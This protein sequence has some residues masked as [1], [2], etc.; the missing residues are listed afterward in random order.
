[1]RC[2]S[3][4]RLRVGKLILGI[5]V[6][7]SFYWN[8]FIKYKDL[9]FQSPRFQLV[10]FVGSFSSICLKTKIVNLTFADRKRAINDHV[11]RSAYFEKCCKA[12]DYC[13]VYCLLYAIIFT[14]QQVLIIKTAHGK[15]DQGKPLGL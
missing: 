8:K 3:Y 14:H 5:L 10:F 13:F 2:Y 15:E 1:M 7:N 4:L 12:I 6:I 9:E 11:L